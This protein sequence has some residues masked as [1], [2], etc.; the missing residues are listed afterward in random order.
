MSTNHFTGIFHERSANFALL[1]GAS[2]R[3]VLLALEVGKLSVWKNKSVPM[4]ANSRKATLVGSY[5]ANHRR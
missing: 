2:T 5:R 4:D 3:K 1:V